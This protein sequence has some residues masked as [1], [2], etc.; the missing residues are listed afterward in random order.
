[1]IKGENIYLRAMELSDIDVIYD[2]ENDTDVWHV[3][4]TYMPF[5]KYFLNEFI[6]KSNNDLYTDKQ[7]RLIIVKNI[8]LQ[9]IGTI[10]LF[11]FDPMHKRAGLGILID[12]NN[13]G[14]NY[15]K[16][17]IKLAKK[18]AFEFLNL[19]QL[20]CNIEDNDISIK[21]FCNANFVIT[22]KKRDWLLINNE[23]KNVVFLQL[24]NS[25]K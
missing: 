17:A 23:W 13:R 21:L 8:D 6:S 18:Y 11:D 2:W 4:N 22:G 24:I 3:S 15:A 19:H 5:S 16:E 7:L 1:M 9:R 20:Y 10:D 14:N 25:S 12:K